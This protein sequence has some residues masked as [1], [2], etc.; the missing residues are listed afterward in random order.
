MTLKEAIEIKERKG[1]ELFNTSP[2]EMAEADRLSFEALKRLRDNRIKF[3]FPHTV[4]LPGE[5]KD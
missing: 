1:G 5:T 3:G 2:A 4:L